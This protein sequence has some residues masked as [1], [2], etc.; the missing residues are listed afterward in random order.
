MGTDILTYILLSGKQEQIDHFINHHRKTVDDMELW[1]CKQFLI[2][3][4]C[5]EYLENPEIDT[6]GR[7]YQGKKSKGINCITLV[8]K[9]S[10]FNEAIKLVCKYYNDLTV[11]I[12]VRDEDYDYGIGWLVIKNRYVLG[13]D[14]IS[15][16]HV[17]NFEK[18]VT[19]NIEIYGEKHRIKDA[20][21]ELKLEF[22]TYDI[23]ELDKNN[24]TFTSIEIPEYHKILKLIKKHSNLHIV[25]RYTG[26]TPHK[27]VGYVVY[28]NKHIISDQFFNLNK[29][30]YSHFYINYFEYCSLDDYIS[31][32]VMN[33]I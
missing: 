22:N 18:E 24:I 8:A 27:F 25:Y 13:E 4:E 19:N 2:D 31:K 26:N 6:C 14:Y 17:S 5:D 1:D 33:F 20:I 10:E 3:N 21:D 28:K 15:L 32:N 16:S 9:Y 12:D 30:E 23:E 7:F 29:D 11:I